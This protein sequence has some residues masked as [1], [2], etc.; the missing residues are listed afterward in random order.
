M[1]TDFQHIYQPGEA[2]Q[3][4]LLLLHGT[5]GNEASLIQLARSVAPRFGVLSPRGR[6]LE[7]GAPRFF[8]R[9][10]EGV[11]DLEDLRFRAGEL[12]A[13]VQD[14]ARHY[15]F[16]AASV[17]ALGYSNGANIAAALLLLH[18]QAL[19]HA[20]LLRVMMPLEV[21]ALPDLA[22]KRVLI[23]AGSEDS[24]IPRASVE[25]LIEVLRRARADVQPVWQQ[26]GHNLTSADLMAME[27]F[28]HGLERA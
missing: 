22:G 24:L 21:E 19:A 13:F 25:R 8:R 28:L 11:F 23:A 2:G 20:V 3:P 15:Q 6:V 27:Q 18:P 14:A 5:G 16:D 26:T 7:H 17:I 9:F 4:T 1:N 12:A 10:A